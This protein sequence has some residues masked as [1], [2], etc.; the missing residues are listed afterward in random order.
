MCDG[1]KGPAPFGGTAFTLVDHCCRHCGG[2]VL[3]AHDGFRCGGCGAVT[4]GSPAGI[5]GCGILPGYSTG[6]KRFACGPNPDRGPQSP[7]EIVILFGDA[8]VA[9]AA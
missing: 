3:Q 5:C 7:S 1:G 2:R 6:M 9:R 4:M 8:P